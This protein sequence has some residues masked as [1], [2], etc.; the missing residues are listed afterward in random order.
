[1]VEIYQK[2]NKEVKKL[3]LKIELRDGNPG[4]INFNTKK[5]PTT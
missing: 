1:M 4:F 5:K 2:Q 3:S